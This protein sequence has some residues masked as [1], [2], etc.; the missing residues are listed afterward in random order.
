MQAE[1]SFSWTASTAEVDVPALCQHDK[2]STTSPA[3][4]VSI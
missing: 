2:V 4:S 1:V 3:L